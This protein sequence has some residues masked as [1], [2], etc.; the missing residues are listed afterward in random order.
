MM[1]VSLHVV[2]RDVTMRGHL[3]LRSRYIAGVVVMCVGA[4]SLVPEYVRPSPALPAS[5]SGAANNGVRDAIPVESGWWR[6][7]GSPELSTLE[8][9]SLTVN[10]NLQAAV[11]RIEEAR[12]T[13]QIAGAPQFPALSL[14]GVVDSS[15]GRSSDL[16]PSRVQNAF[17]LASYEIDFW[18]KNRASAASARELVDASEFDRDTAA[19]TLAA[20]VADT[21][22]QILSLRERI[23][24]AQRIARGAA[25]IL[26]LIEARASVGTASEVDVEQQRNAVATFNAAIPI[27]RQQLEQSLH[28]LA[29]L[30]GVAPEG[31][32]VSTRH[33]SELAIPTI[34]ANLPAAIL[35]QRPDIRAAEARLVAANFSVGAARAAFYPSIRL[36]A[37]GGIA[38][39]SLSQFF[40]LAQGLSELGGTLTQPLFSGWQLEGQLHLNRAQVVELT[41]S[42]RQSVIAALQDVEDSLTAV[43]QLQGLER[44]D[45]TAANSARRAA[46]LTAA[47][48]RLGTVDFLTVLTVERT[49]FQAED[50]LLQ[51]RMQRLQAVVGL[52]RALG[53][54]FSAAW[55]EAADAGTGGT[56]QD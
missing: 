26:T 12:G 22:F 54:G 41:A 4:C 10:Y 46:N 39:P 52:F 6:S 18:G 29:I 32:A 31:F 23:G 5:W 53:G 21:F 14:N 11:A 8:E 56:S 37:A 40:P 36:T 13:A 9:R 48:F 43:A 19:M 51:V 3:D 33:L 28:L 30:V 20:S 38:S 35:Q 55:T 16:K 2:L 7:F 24:V 47:E 49:L 50:A 1:P 45:T 25:R 27:L 15:T 17:V 34:Q 42:Y 44:A